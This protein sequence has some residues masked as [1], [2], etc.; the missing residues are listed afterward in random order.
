MRRKSTIVPLHKNNS[1]IQGGSNYC[2]I[3]LIYHTIKFWKKE[4]EHTCEGKIKNQSHA[5]DIEDRCYSFLHQ[6]IERFQERTRNLF[7]V[8]IN[9]E[10]TYDRVLREVL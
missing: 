2:E 5:K 10:K 9:L 3:K 7:I 8:F 4:I 6:L 1:D